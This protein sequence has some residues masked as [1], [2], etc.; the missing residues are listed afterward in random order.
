MTTTCSPIKENAI[1]LKNINREII[2]LNNEMLFIKNELTCIRDI[3]K[4]DCDNIKVEVIED[5][6]TPMKIDTPIQ[7]EIA[8]QKGWFW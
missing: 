3:L 5:K 6:P 7:T 8:T 2:K 4:M 1:L